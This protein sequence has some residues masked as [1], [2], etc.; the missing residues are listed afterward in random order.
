MVALKTLLAPG[1]LGKEVRRSFI[2]RFERE[3]KAAGRM[4]HPYI[5]T[6]FDV[7][8]DAENPYL[9]MEYVPGETLAA[10]LDRGRMPLADAVSCASNLAGALGFAHAQRIVALQHFLDDIYGDFARFDAIRLRVQDLA[11]QAG[12]QALASPPVVAALDEW[13]AC[14]SKSGY[15]VVDPAEA[16]RIGLSTESEPDESELRQAEVDVAARKRSA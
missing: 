2:E 12:V 1:Y 4:A 6:I 3:A 8:L 15:A 13:K 7:G 14:M 16:E 11:S 5:V 10:R 9:V